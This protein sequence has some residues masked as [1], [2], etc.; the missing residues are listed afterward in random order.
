MN[1]WQMAGG[2][3]VGEFLVA[4]PLFAAIN[5]FLGPRRSIGWFAIA[6]IKGVLERAVMFVGLVQGF[7]HVLT[8]IGAVKL[9]TRLQGD[10]DSELSNTYFY[11]G[12]VLSMLLALLYTAIARTGL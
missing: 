4:M 8:A 6:M 12:T 10:R 1:A 11:T 9:G 5:R 7:P 2:F 3:L